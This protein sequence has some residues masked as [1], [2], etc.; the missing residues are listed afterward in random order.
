M[1]KITLSTIKSF[2]KREM[3]KDNLYISKKA[4]FDGMQDMVDDCRDTS[5]KKAVKDE[6]N[7]RNRQGVSGAWF[8]G[9][10]RD[11]FREY[12]DNNFIGYEIFN[13]CGKFILAFHK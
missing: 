13:C 9:Q 1:T 12:A 2:I 11:S 8:V 10:S 4:D 5:F 6:T 7:P 3:A